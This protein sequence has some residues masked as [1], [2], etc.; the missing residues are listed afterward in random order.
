MQEKDFSWYKDNLPSLHEQYGNKYVAIKNQHVLGSYDSYADGVVET[1]KT[2][3]VG[4]FII[5]QCGS[6]ESA[7]TCH[8]SSM[9]FMS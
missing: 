5:Q 7:Y 2:E 8:I 1:S 4:T 3:P 9:N 6:D